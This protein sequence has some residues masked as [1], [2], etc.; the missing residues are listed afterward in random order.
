MSSVSEDYA[1]LFCELFDRLDPAQFHAEG[2][3]WMADAKVAAAAAGVEQAALDGERVA[4]PTVGVR[5]SR[6]C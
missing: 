4:A 3:T 6:S 2:E 1:D 5:P